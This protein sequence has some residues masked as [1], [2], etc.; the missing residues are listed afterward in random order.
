[1]P[2]IQAVFETASPSTLVEPKTVTVD[3]ITGQ[4]PAAAAVELSP[5]VDAAPVFYPPA[6]F[7]CIFKARSHNV[8]TREAVQTTVTKTVPLFLKLT[9]KRP[10]V[11]QP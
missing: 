3:S 11:R 7:S 6:T 8:M 9:H 10:K 2:A 1:M 5:I 4:Q